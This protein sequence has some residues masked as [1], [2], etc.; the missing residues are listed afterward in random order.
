MQSSAPLTPTLSPSDGEREK[1]PNERYNVRPDK[2]HRDVGSGQAHWN[3]TSR[4]LLPLFS[5][6]VEGRLDCLSILRTFD[7]V[8]RL[9]VLDAFHRLQ[10]GRAVEIFFRRQTHRLRQFAILDAH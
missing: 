4:A 3:L 9:S 2:S 6:R 8:M 7:L 1:K 10:A 5:R